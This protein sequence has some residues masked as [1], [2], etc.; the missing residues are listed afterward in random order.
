MSSKIATPEGCTAEIEQGIE[1]PSDTTESVA[2]PSCVEQDPVGVIEALI[3]VSGEPLSVGRIQEVTSLSESEVRSALDVIKARQDEEGR[4]FEL[5]QVAGQQY[6]FRTKAQFGECICELKAN[7]PRRLSPAA[8]ET[9]AIIAYRQ[10][11]V[12]S[13]IEKLRGVDAT[14]TVKT[15]LERKLIKIVGHK[16]TVGQPALYGTTDEFLKLFGL[17][18]LTEL[19]TL[20]DIRELERDP[21]EN[22]EQLELDAGDS[23]DEG[24][25]EAASSE[26][27]P[28]VTGENESVEEPTVECR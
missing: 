24:V 13:D 21:G 20:R 15:L 22:G 28:Q 27:G 18:S 1:T 7:R 3:F 2:I 11:I 12:R 8:L 23:T 5:V 14:P 9:L 17:Q 4:G 19:P 25:N 16:Q 26:D 6:Q 10:P